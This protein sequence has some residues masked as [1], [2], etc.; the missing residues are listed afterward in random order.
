MRPEAKDRVK[1]LMDTRG[2]EIR[3]GYFEV[4][5]LAPRSHARVRRPNSRKVIAAIFVAL[6]VRCTTPKRS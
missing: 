5:Q 1:I 6:G 2:P 3:T 4:P